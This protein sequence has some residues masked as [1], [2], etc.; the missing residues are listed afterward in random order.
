MKKK[1]LEST[2]IVHAT[3]GRCKEYI[4]TTT[5]TGMVYGTFCGER[6]CSYC[7][8]LV[9]SKRDIGN[10]AVIDWEEFWKQEFK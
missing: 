2:I 4:D 9:I 7:L 1:R 6:L 10:Y 8:N 3:C 5:L